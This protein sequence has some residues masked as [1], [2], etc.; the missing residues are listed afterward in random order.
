LR[1]SLSGFFVTTRQFI[2]TEETVILMKRARVMI[3]ALFATFLCLVAPAVGIAADAPIKVATVSLPDI[4]T[5]STA[6]Q[7]AKKLLEA[8]VVEFQTKIQQEQQKQDLMR[9]EI[10][11][12]SSMWREEVR[13]EKEREL[14]KKGQELKVMSE[15]AQF[16]LQQMEK[17][18]MEPILTELHEVIA[19]IGSKRGFTL[20][21][22]NTKK[23][24]ESRSGLLYAAE[25]LD[26]SD[27][28]R[29]ALEKRMAAV[30]KKEGEG[31]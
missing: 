30:N 31:K 18:L 23:G 16:E 9:A 10:D 3:T 1:D 4:I 22:E 2:F 17:K 12:K 24:L 25:P 11:K 26:I 20:I 28:V 5:K 15:D 29:E 14:L 7:E 19:E 6:G 27:L 8:K 21:F 13:M